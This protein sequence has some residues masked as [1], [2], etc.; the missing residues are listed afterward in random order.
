MEYKAS[1]HSIEKI[2]KRVLNKHFKV[3][4]PL[5]LFLSILC[6]TS[7]QSE[8][9]K[10]ETTS[11][12]EKVLPTENDSLAIRQAFEK[13][14]TDPQFLREMGL[15]GET[16]YSLYE[17]P[18][19]KTIRGDL[20]GDGSIDA[21]LPFT[22]EGRGGGGN[23]ADFNYLALLHKN[24]DWINGGAM[25]ASVFVDAIIFTAQKIE[26]GIIYG[27]WQGKLNDEK[28]Y[29]AEFVLRN[30]EFIPIYEELHTLQ[31]EE[32][33]KI[34]LYRI[35]TKD[36]QNI[37]KE[38]SLKE[39][40]KL[41][42]KGKISTPKEQPECGTYWDE[43]ITRYLDYPNFHFELND[44]N[45][46]GWMAK[47][48]TG[49]GLVLYTDHGTISEH[50]TA[51]ELKTIFKNPDSWDVETDGTSILTLMLGDSDDLV[52]LYFSKNG[53]LEKV[54]HVVQC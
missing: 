45:E 12:I 11:V 19:I 28:P 27:N 46:A 1:I 2:N 39:I 23:N 20:D 47:L 5:I 29:Q 54:I 10:Q 25:D 42:G 32:D 8:T 16:G 14:K 21:L 48:L 7:C 35:Y 40:E 49:S 36:Y 30:R 15:E 50:T 37:P 53:K 41:L 44:Q 52:R 13:L 22:I 33:D 43:G 17:E 6:L 3:M 24:N 26:N 31:E 18:K 9:K 34:Y 51:K 38:G 4:K